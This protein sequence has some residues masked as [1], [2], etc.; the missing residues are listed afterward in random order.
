MVLVLS[1]CLI[2]LYICIKFHGNISKDFRAI[3]GLLFPSSGFPKG[4]NSVKNAGRVM[5]LVLC[6]LSN[7]AL[8]FYKIS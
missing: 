7:H 5:A 1:C 8:Y 4:H 6:I 3:E 2:L